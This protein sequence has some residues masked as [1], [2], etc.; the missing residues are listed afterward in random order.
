MACRWD[1]YKI[2]MIP[3]LPETRICQLV[4]IKDQFFVYEINKNVTRAARLARD[5]ASLTDRSSA[6]SWH[7]GTLA[8]DLNRS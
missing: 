5:G 8:A 6:A 1:A 7:L 2:L 3:D 4:Q